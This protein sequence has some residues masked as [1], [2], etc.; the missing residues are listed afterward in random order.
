MKNR[1]T[2][3]IRSATVAAAQHL[4]APVEVQVGPVSCG[5]RSI[6][7]SWR[8]SASATRPPWPNEVGDWYSMRSRGVCHPA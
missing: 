3:P 8:V 4:P 2:N 7:S 6:E 1:A 5:K